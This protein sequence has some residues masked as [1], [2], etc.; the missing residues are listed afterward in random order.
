VVGFQ[1]MIHPTER[2]SGKLAQMK[3][4]QETEDATRVTPIRTVRLFLYSDL[5]AAK[6]DLEHGRIEFP[7]NTA[8]SADG[9]LSYLIQTYSEYVHDKGI[10]TTNSMSASHN[11]ASNCGPCRLVSGVTAVFT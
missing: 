9:I 1:S 10:T 6:E 7:V 5:S 8:E 4:K 3:S 11:D 2:L